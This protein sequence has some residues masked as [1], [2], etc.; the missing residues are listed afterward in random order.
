MNDMLYPIRVG[1]DGDW[2][3]N[4]SIQTP[5]SETSYHV[6]G[7]LPYT[8]YSFRVIAVNAKGPS[9]PSKESYYMVTLREG[10]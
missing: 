10:K 2:D 4:N 9:R 5:D 7:L 8:V 1:E 3:A 6:K